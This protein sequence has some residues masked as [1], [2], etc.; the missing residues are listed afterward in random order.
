MILICCQYHI[1]VYQKDI[2]GEHE[3]FHKW[4]LSIIN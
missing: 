3:H 4:D 2:L 1:K